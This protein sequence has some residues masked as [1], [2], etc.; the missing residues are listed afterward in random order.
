DGLSAAIDRVH[1]YFEL[2]ADI[3]FIEAPVS[4]EEM[5][6]IGAAFKGKPLV[7]NL[8]EGGKTPLLAAAD[9]ERLGFKIMFCANTVLRAMI[10]GV[11]DALKV[12]R[13][14]GDQTRVLEMICAWE[15]RQ[16]IVETDRLLNLGARYDQIAASD[17]AAD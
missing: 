9:L 4:V 13:Q 3:G 14:D 15:E 2:G 8:V 11:S 5:R 12:L 6:T 1:R 7:I 16:S 17:P 10:K